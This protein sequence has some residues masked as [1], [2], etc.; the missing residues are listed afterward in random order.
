[1]SRTWTSRAGVSITDLVPASLRREWVRRG[2]CP[3]RDVYTAFRER[4]R[5]HGTREAVRDDE[6]SL[7][8]TALDREVRRVAGALAEHGVGELDIVG[9]RMPNGWRHV[10][11][12]LAVAALG[13]VALVYPPGPGRRDTAALLGRSRARAAVFGAAADADR[14]GDLPHLSA[15]FTFGAGELGARSLDAADPQREVPAVAVD[16]EAPARILVTSGSQAEPK[17]VAYAHN[18]VLGGRANYVRALQRECDPMRAAMLMPLG[19]SYGSCATFVAIAALGSTVLLQPRFD[20]AAALR[21]VESAGATH[22]FGV[23][24]MLRRL[25]EHPRAAAEDLSGLRAVVS[26]S[27]PLSEVTARACGDRLGAEVISVYG[28]TDGMNCHTAATGLGAGTG[29]PDP[30]VAE[31]GIADE[32]GTWLPADEPGEVLARGPMTPL[33]YVAAPDL[34]ERYRTPA[35]WVRSGDRGV[36]DARGRLHVLGRLEQ[37]VVRGGYTISPAEVE[38]EITAHP[39]VVDV[40]CVGVPDDDLG[41][42]MCACISLAAGSSGLELGA[43]TGFLERERGLERRKLPELLL[44]LA[45]LPQAPTGKVCRRT[46]QALATEQCRPPLAEEIR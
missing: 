18:A 45:E 5:A 40:V 41:E 44:V 21:L 22:L 34:D 14:T 46:T 39:E 16:P 19:S 31:I 30:S 2:D 35:G 27:A 32:R 4:V 29:A 25:A 15:A 24:T 9:I 38:R 36:L 42:R 26:S 33:S 1:M 28:S 3:D 13:A 17:M 7:D 11:A 43:L 12:E 10:V 6:R 20:P 37:V 8:Y 23:P